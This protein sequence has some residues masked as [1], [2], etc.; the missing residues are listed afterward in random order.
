MS[1]DAPFRVP[2]R[3]P[4]STPLQGTLVAHELQR[5][6]FQGELLLPHEPSY[7]AFASASN[8]A[9]ASKLP[10]LIALP[11]H[12]A[13]VAVVMRAASAAA[14]RG[15]TSFGLAVRGG[16][17]SFT[18]TSST[19]GLLQHLGKLDTVSTTPST[20]LLAVG[21]GA[22]WQQA[23]AIARDF[24]LVPIHGE[25]SSVGVVGSSIHGGLSYSVL[26]T[27]MMRE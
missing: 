12:S 24:G 13:D 21:A 10:A 8:P 4:L 5:D 19:T 3:A 22:T 9:C 15:D 16:G 11:Q 18:C 6:G 17:H 1:D 7:E 26:H 27:P 2:F 25:C 14:S 20:E 23:E